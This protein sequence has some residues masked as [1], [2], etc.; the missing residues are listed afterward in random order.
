MVLALER[1]ERGGEPGR[2]SLAHL[3][4]AVIGFLFAASGP[5]AIILAAGAKGGLDEATIASWVFGAFALNALITATFC[6]LYRQP[7]VFF[8]TIPGTVLV[9][10]ALPGLSYPEVI[11]A[12][13]IAGA[14]M[15]V[16][17]L[18]G[19][20]RRAMEALPQPIV[21]AMVAGV[22]LQFG[23]DLVRAFAADLLIAVAM[24]AAFAAATAMPLLARWLPPLL[25]AFAAGIAAVIMRGIE[26]PAI[27]LATA[28]AAPVVHVPV[29]SWP[30]MVELV[31]PLM[32]TVLAVQNAQGVAVLTQAGHR[33]PVNAIAVACGI[34]SIA[35]AFVGTAS[36][37]LTGPVNS[38]LS[39]SGDRSRQYVSGLIVAA[40]ALVFGLLSPLLVRLMLAAPAAFI[41]VLAGLAML[42]VLQ[43]AFATAFRGP[44]GLGA[45][46]TFLVTVAG[47]PIL[48]IGA[49]FWG[50]VLGYAV[51]LLLEGQ[52]FAKRAG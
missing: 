33:P 37:C 39:S 43:S 22:F 44:F 24:T 25:A 40:L 48:N 28:V 4:N 18:S 11:G 29:F 17:G 30:A 32:I 31:V 16:L 19:L 8:W 26:V 13:L 38:I 27:S 9:G 34:G 36:T 52:D 35:V 23:L 1:P 3:A 6:L 50:L 12:Y 14:L 2:L 49:P 42:R 41:S 45:L 5:L 21:M 47:Q 51:S 15:V 20:V 7:L 10:A 46:V